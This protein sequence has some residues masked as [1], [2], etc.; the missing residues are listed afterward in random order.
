VEALPISFLM[1]LVLFWIIYTGGIKAQS[2]NILDLVGLV[3]YL[4]G[5]FINTVSELTR[6]KWKSRPENQGHL[7]TGGLFKRVR[8]INYFGDIVLFAGLALI[9]QDPGLLFI[10]LFMALNFVLILIPA[11]EAHLKEKYGEAFEPYSK[12]SKKF[13]PLIY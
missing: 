3:L 1:S 8:H 2:L 10:P 13:I 6:H 9:A 7:Y 11:K 12:R 5:S 4:T